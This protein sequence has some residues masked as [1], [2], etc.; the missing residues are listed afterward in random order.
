MGAKKQKRNNI[1][2]FSLKAKTSDVDLTPI[3]SKSEK[4]GGKW[5]ITEKFDAMD[6]Q[7][8]DIRSLNYEFEDEQKTKV[9]LTLRDEDGSINI[10]GANFNGLTYTLLNC[11]ANCDKIGKIDMAVWLGKAN[12]Q[13]KQY[14]SISVKNDPFLVGDPEQCK[15]KY[16]YADLPKVEKVKVKN[17]I[18]TD[19]TA[20]VEFFV[21]V[22]NEEIKP[23]LQPFKGKPT[24]PTEATPATATA[25]ATVAE[26]A[27]T[28]S[29]AADAPP[30]D[31]LPF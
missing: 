15:W 30:D 29:M 13:G 17:K 6:G 20:L 7:L 2:Y 5:T 11:L 18:V 9:E 23:K 24:G 12:E 28:S 10:V 19:D 8:T 31:D 26:P 21:K 25:Q 22:I 4:V 27:Q 3:F 1:N 16:K 14:P